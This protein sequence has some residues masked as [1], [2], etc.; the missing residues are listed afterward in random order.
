LV[1]AGEADAAVVATAGVLVSGASR[2]LRR[3]LAPIEWIVLEDLALDATDDGDGRL[4]ATTSARQIAEHLSISPGSAAKALGALR[5][6]G[7]VTHARRPGPQ[8][9]FGLSVYALAGVPGLEVV[10]ASGSTSEPPG[11]DS[12]RAASLCVPSPRVAEPHMAKAPVASNLAQPTSS[13]RPQRAARPAPD[14]SVQLDLLKPAT[15]LPT[16][17]HASTRH[18]SP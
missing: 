9:R 7:L 18:P 12:P 10:G 16:A 1:S 4:T 15:D 8:G 13:K 6:R 5:S 3:S 11:V 17:R 14:D 2:S